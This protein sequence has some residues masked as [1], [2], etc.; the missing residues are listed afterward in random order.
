VHAATTHQALPPRIRLPLALTAALALV[1]ACGGPVPSIAP[2]L[3][4]SL[5]PVADTPLPTGPLDPAL[6]WQ[7]IDLTGV[8]T[9]DRL[10][11]VIV[12]R[13]GFIAVGGGGKA[14][15]EPI[16]V[17]SPDGLS[18]R[19]EPIASSYAQPAELAIVGDAIVAIGAGGTSRCAHPFALDT[20][21]RT[22][23]GRWSEAPW[24]AAFCNGLNEG[25]LL[26]WRG[27][28]WLVASGSGDQPFLW[29][30][31]DGLR[32]TSHGTVG[33]LLPTA[34]VVEG[35]SLLAFGQDEAGEIAARTTMD[36]VAWSSVPL[37]PGASERVVA[38]FVRA[39]RLG[40]FIDRSG[41]IDVL[42]RDAAGVA[43]IV[44]TTGMEGVPDPGTFI[45]VGDRVVRL[46]ADPDQLPA[47]WSSSDG[48]QWTPIQ[49]PADSGPGTTFTGIA[50]LDGTAVLVGQALRGDGSSSI[51]AIWTGSASLLG[52]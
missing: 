35:D 12:T 51:G 39:G 33:G 19:S 23:A 46:T 52:G 36:G 42:T 7:R 24:S 3:L 40:V 5:P 44:R 31:V 18:W 1:E 37:P 13:E 22:A 26:A 14:G 29:S 32:W 43:S 34:A 47:G 45:D 38:A 17:A 49:L 6:G 4:P 8:A 10:S 15:L 9:P 2:S 28:A 27:A 11:A 48:V 50:V 41:R 25:H 20:W 16:A 21:A 30:S